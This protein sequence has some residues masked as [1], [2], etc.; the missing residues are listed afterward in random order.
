MRS[1]TF[2]GFAVVATAALGLIWFLTP[3]QP[4]PAIGDLQI[5]N[6]AAQD[7][8]SGGERV[9]G[10]PFEPVLV[11]VIDGDTFA[12]GEEHVRLENIDTPETGGRAECV[13]ER[14]L[15]ELA[16]ERARQW[17]HVANT[18]RIER[19]GTDC[20]GRTLAL[21]SI[22]GA[23]LGERLIADGLAVQWA[24]RQHHWCASLEVGAYEG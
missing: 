24:G 18:A 20:F 16:T 19:T 11:R 7:F 2:S 1:G 13:F 15:A 21:V 4:S 23:D 17:F 5:S 3:D 12:L 10:E 22:D 6:E 8:S 9:V 14:D